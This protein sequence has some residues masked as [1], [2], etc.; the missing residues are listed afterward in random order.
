MAAIAIAA[1]TAW[2]AVRTRPS[3]AQPPAPAPPGRPGPLARSNSLGM[4]LVYVPP[5]EFVMGAP[6]ADGDAEDW[7]RPAHLVRIRRAFYL[8]ATEVTVREFRAFADATG[9]RTEAESSGKGGWAW[10]G[11]RKQ[12]EQRPELTWRHPWLGGDPLE[13]QPVLQV[14]WN[15]ADAFCRWLARKEGRPYR[16][17]TEA[18]WEYACRA[19]TTTRWSTGDDPARLDQAAWFDATSGFAPHPVGLKA[20]NPLRLH[21]M[22]GNA[23]EWC[24]DWFGAYAAG[25]VADPTGPSEGQARVMR[26]GAWDWKATKARSAAREPVAPGYCDTTDGFRVCQPDPAR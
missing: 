14:T 16:L 7:E 8:G 4:R 23:R 17:P 26:G 25:E 22:H 20:A 3:A 6:A 12:L 19:G 2:Y 21:D 11:E 5:G 9:Y 13:D 15:D 10:N 24:A 18:E 1:A